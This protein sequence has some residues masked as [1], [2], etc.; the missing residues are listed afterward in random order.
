MKK[1]YSPT[2][3]C[4]HRW[5]KPLHW[6]VVPFALALFA[7]NVWNNWFYWASAIVAG[8]AAT[9]G[10]RVIH[11]KRRPRSE[12][13]TVKDVLQDLRDSPTE[14]ELHEEDARY[15]GTGWRVLEVRK[16]WARTAV[17]L[18]AFVLLAVG[19][20]A[21]AT[22]T[23]PVKSAQMVESVSLA[24]VLLPTLVGVLLALFVAYAHKKATQPRKTKRA[25]LPAFLRTNI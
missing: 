1:P 15:E 10:S 8:V 25:W 24:V 23:D 20:G 13:A 5:C 22:F 11:F 9:W 4:P 16:G 19:W 2:R 12:P 17:A 6:G 18:D 14:W 21:T 7:F 3:L